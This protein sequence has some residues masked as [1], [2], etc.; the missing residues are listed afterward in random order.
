MVRKEGLE[1]FL[2]RTIRGSRL[3]RSYLGQ[4]I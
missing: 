2:T 1:P 4:T 3:I